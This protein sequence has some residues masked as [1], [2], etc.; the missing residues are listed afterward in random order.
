MCN[1]Q[2]WRNY[3]Q[4]REVTK[5]KILLEKYVLAVKQILYDMGNSGQ[6]YKVNNGPLTCNFSEVAG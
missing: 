5:K 1:C 2:T 3:L 6:V 4:D